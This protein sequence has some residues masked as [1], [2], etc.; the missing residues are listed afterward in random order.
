M[1]LERESAWVY[2]LLWSPRNLQ[3]HICKKRDNSVFFVRLNKFRNNNF[4]KHCII[5]AIFRELELH[6]PM[7]N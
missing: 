7:N 1:G 3:N 4:E 6:M 2:V 5:G